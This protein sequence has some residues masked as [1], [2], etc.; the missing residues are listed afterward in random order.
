[1]RANSFSITANGL[2]NID[3]KLLVS[4]RIFVNRVVLHLIKLNDFQMAAIIIS[5]SVIL[6]N[7]GAVSQHNS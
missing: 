5:Y 4:V 3:W 2:I 6:E 1:M 7:F